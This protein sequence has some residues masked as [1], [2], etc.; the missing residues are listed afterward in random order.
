VISTL[1]FS[2]EGT[3]REDHLYGTSDDLMFYFT[4]MTGY[5]FWDVCICIFQNWELPFKF[6]AFACFS[7]YFFSL[8][9]FVQFYMAIVLLFELSTP[10]LHLRWFLVKLDMAKG[11]LFLFV[12][13]MFFLSFTFARVLMG[14]ITTV[15]AFYEI[16]SYIFKGTE[17]NLIVCLLFIMCGFGLNGLN[18]YWYSLILIKLLG[19]S[20]DKDKQQDSQ[21]SSNADGTT[22]SNSNST[23]NGNGNGNGD[24]VLDM[25][26]DDMSGGALLASA[27]EFV[28]SPFMKSKGYENINSLPDDASPC[29]HAHAHTHATRRSRALSNGDLVKVNSNLSLNLN[30]HLSPSLNGH[31]SPST[32]MAVGYGALNVHGREREEEYYHLNYNQQRR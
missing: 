32:R 19:S 15:S 24:C 20:D 31:Q 6:H 21:S 13:A 5:F 3:F 7:V 28:S 18:I 9:P 26:M 29:L 22:N 2:Q 8:Y 14:P 25:D 12:Q 11:K 17:H 1:L 30:V 27:A 10:W 4:I 16:S 23:G